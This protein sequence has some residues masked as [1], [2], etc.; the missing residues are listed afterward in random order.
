MTGKKNPLGYS[1]GA[2]TRKKHLAGWADTM[3][4]GANTTKTF[5]LECAAQFKAIT[6]DC[7]LFYQGIGNKFRLHVVILFAK[8]AKQTASIP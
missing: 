2:N 6:L 7:P 4:R 8:Q 3:L 1:T 5:R